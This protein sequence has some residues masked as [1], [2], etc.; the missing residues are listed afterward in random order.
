MKKLIITMFAL[1][2][3]TAARAQDIPQSEVPSVVLNA[4]QA[5]FASAQNVEWELK[6]EEYKGEFK[7]GKRGHDVWIDK[8]GKIRKHKEDFPKS[9]LPAPI[10]QQLEKQFSA[11]KIEDVDKIDTNGKI[12]YQVELDGANGAGDKKILFAPDGKIEQTK[13]D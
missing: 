9:E 4:F 5:K 6:G 10:K 1:A 7:V 11:Y 2:T 8:T 3:L 12:Q 13:A